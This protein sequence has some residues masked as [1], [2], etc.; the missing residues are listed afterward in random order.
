[1]FRAHSARTRQKSG[2]E[3]VKK[4]FVQPQ[5]FSGVQLVGDHGARCTCC[6]TCCRGVSER[7]HM[8]AQSNFFS[9]GRY[10]YFAMQPKQCG[11]LVLHK[12]NRDKT[13]VHWLMTNS[14][15]VLAETRYCRLVINCVSCKAWFH[16]L[17]QRPK[18]VTAS[19]HPKSLTHRLHLPR[20]EFHRYLPWIS[21]FDTARDTIILPLKSREYTH[22]SQQHEGILSYMTHR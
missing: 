14:A 8:Q 4:I 20:R 12:D 15:S 2:R 17:F 9:S 18:P 21:S 19:H 7:I 3:R 16:S 5:L 13:E 6:C 11:E 10:R 22:G 1:M